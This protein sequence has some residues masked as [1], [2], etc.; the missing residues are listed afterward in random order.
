MIDAPPK[1]DPPTEGFLRHSGLDTSKIRPMGLNE[2]LFPPSPKVIEAMEANPNPQPGLFRRLWDQWPVKVAIIVICTLWLIPTIGLLLSSVRT[3]ALIES[4]GWW[5]FF[6]KPFETTL[7][8]A[9]LNTVFPEDFPYVNSI[10]LKSDVKISSL[11]TDFFDKVAGA[12]KATPS[13]LVGLI[14]DE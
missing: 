6:S 10:V 7:G 1:V 8:R 4:E 2:S 14:P 11:E 9:I 3:T 12:L 13:E 5:T